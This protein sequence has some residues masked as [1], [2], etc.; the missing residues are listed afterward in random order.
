MADSQLL[1][2]DLFGEIR[3]EQGENSATIVRD[4]AAAS[5]WVR[6]LARWMMRRE[7]RVLARLEN[8]D[9][10]PHIVALGHSHL[11]RGF[12]QGAPMQ[13]ARPRDPAYFR[14]ALRLL[15]RLHAANVAH[16]DLAKEPNFLVRPD[17]TPG[18]LDFQLAFHAPRRGK[19]FRLAAREDLRHLLKHKRQY[20]AS[21]LTQRQRAILDSPSI[22]SR[23]FARTIKP[24]YLF[25]TRKILG[26]QDREGAGNRGDI[27]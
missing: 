2:K 15:R 11:E 26:W 7:A 18:I 21:S 16:N 9:G 5:L 20:C 22:P 10:V 12:L 4:C 13:L 19:M 24:V 3:L 8:L 17:G 23:L 27:Q 25:V 1:K 14:H 6:G